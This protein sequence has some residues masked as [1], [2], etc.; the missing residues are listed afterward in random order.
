VFEGEQETRATVIADGEPN[1]HDILRLQGV[2][3]LANYLVAKSRTSTACR[4]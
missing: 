2:E 3:A 4:A 1:P